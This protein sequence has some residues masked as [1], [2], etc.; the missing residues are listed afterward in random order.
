MVSAY[1]QINGNINSY[2]LGITL[3]IGYSERIIFRMRMLLLHMKCKT[4]RRFKLMI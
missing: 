2:V 4:R 3:N 1:K